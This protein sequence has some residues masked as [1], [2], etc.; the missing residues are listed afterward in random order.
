MIDS[1]GMST[2]KIGHIQRCVQRPVRPLHVND[3]ANR[4][5]AS[6]YYPGPL[7]YGFIMPPGLSAR[8]DD[9]HHSIIAPVYW[10]IVPALQPDQDTKL[11]D[12]PTGHVETEAS[13]W[14]EAPKHARAL[15]FFV[16]YAKQPRELALLGDEG[17]YAGG[18]GVE[19]VGD[20]TLLLI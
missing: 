1:S 18:L 9:R 16:T 13:N 11:R 4:T 17:V 5:V 6:G 2:T 19:E 3:L 15:L 10:K 14:V 8:I 12:A 7:D 20:G